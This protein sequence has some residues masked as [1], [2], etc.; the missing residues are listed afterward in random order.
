MPK[1]VQNNRCVGSHPS[2]I[3]LHINASYGIYTN[4]IIWTIMDEMRNAYKILVGKPEGKTPLS[5]PRRRREDKIGMNLGRQS[6]K[7]WTSFIRL[8]RGTSGGL[9]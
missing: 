1:A 7:L 5:R 6:G 2:N 3:L 8:R 9:L 4:S